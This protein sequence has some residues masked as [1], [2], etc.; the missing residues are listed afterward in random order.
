M[1]P[2]DPENGAPPREGAASESFPKADRLR[3]PFEFKAFRE[4]RDTMRAGLGPFTALI[5]ANG[6][7]HNRLGLVVSKKAG[8]AVRRN[9]LKRLAREWFRTRAGTLPKGFDLLLIARTP[10]GPGK[11]PWPRLTGTESGEALLRT[12]S[13]AITK[14][15]PFDLGDPNPP[16]KDQDAPVGKDG[17]DGQGDPES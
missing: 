14:L 17:P 12:I 4:R 6:L 10:R 13:L 5:G 9:R 15:G 1:P 11:P 2:K 8:N 7:G 16:A 3:K